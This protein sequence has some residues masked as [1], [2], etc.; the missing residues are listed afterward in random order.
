M[1]RIETAL[2]ELADG[3]R[4]GIVLRF[5]AGWTLD[6]IGRQTRSTRSSVYKLIDRGLTHLAKTGAF[7]IADLA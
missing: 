1:R 6:E 3:Q 7:A 5:C 4:L 2:G